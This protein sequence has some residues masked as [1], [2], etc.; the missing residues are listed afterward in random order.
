MILAAQAR[1]RKPDGDGQGAAILRGVESELRE[2]RARWWPTARVATGGVSNAVSTRRPVASPRSSALPTLVALL[3]AG[4]SVDGCAS[5]RPMA[6]TPTSSSNTPRLVTTSGRT[7]ELDF[8]EEVRPPDS[9]AAL[10]IQHGCPDSLVDLADGT[11][12][13]LIEQP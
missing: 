1:D 9:V 2:Y 10:L 4:V 7:Q 13:D 5:Y 6:L 11:D 3:A 12:L 8:T